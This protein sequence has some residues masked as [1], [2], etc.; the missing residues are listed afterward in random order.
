MEHLWPIVNLNTVNSTNIYAL[1]LIKQDQDLT[2]RVISTRMQSNGKGQ[3][4]N[5]WESEPNCN[6]TFSLI[7]KPKELKAENQFAITI[8]AS[9]GILDFLNENKISSRIKW[10]NDILHGRKK[11]AGI[12]IENTII[13]ELIQHSVIGIGLNINQANFK[14]LSDTAISM[15]EITGMYY[16]LDIALHQL[17]NCLNSR[18][19]QMYKTDFSQFKNI[20]LEHLY[21]F[22]K[23][24]KY[25]DMNHHFEGKIIDVLDTGELVLE[26]EHG[27][28]STFMHKEIALV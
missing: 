23:W 8:A 24:L 17:L 21:G 19:E 10:P 12:L 14:Q 13:G 4:R 20:Y 25:S 27:Q 16:N 26:D 28:Q 18:I 7:I 5:S 1:E 9:L 3:D 11:I 6:L 22:Q 2:E 15:K